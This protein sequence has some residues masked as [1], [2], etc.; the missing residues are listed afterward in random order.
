MNGLPRSSTR[1]HQSLVLTM[2]LSYATHDKHIQK[3]K[4]NRKLF[5]IVLLRVRFCG[6]CYQKG[7]GQ[8]S[9][10][11]WYYDIDSAFFGVSHAKGAP[12][13]ATPSGC[14]RTPRV[15]RMY[16]PVYLLVYS[17]QYTVYIIH[18]GQNETAPRCQHCLLFVY[19]H[20]G[21]TKCILRSIHTY[22]SVLVWNGRPP[23]W[24]NNG[25]LRC[26]RAGQGCTVT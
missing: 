3:T 20:H 8:N 22:S 5:A 12:L 11:G 1:H 9:R 26:V 25:I 14:V 13:L 15:G 6:A 21:L 24:E 18:F 23:Q 4:I 2:A 19:E 16:P 17:M 10:L 7:A